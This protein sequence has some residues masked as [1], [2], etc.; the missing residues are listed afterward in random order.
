MISLVSPVAVV[1]E[2][3][4][5]CNFKCPQCRAF[6]DN[7]KRNTDIENAVIEAVIANK[8]LS[9]NIS[10]GEPLLHPEIV[11]IVRRL[12]EN[13]VDV[14]ISTNGW[15]YRNMAQ[16]LK[17]VGLK[18]VQISIDGPEQIHDTFRGKKGAHKMAQDSIKTAIKMGHYV[19]MNVTLTSV[20]LPYVLDNIHL[21]EQLNVN[22]VFFRRVVSAGLSKTNSFVLPE[23]KAYLNAINQIAS[24][25]KNSN[26]QISIDDPI[27]RVLQGIDSR[28]NYLSCSAGITSLGIDSDGDIYPCIFLREKLGNILTDDISAIWQKSTILQK[29]RERKI[30]GCGGCDYKYVC[31]GCRAFSGILEKDSFCPL[32]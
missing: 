14:G 11:S 27:Y 1:W 17:D 21:A 7:P 28:E 6:M 25:P 2:I 22:R 26:L 15:L 24:Y 23:K 3:T 10:G 18:F 5:K 29:L 20:N 9:I 19:Q 16:D 4:N 31:G 12:S 32:E 30:S 13:G 8:I